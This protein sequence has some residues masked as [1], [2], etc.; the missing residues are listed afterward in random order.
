MNEEIGWQKFCKGNPELLINHDM[1]IHMAF[2]A[3]WLAGKEA[4]K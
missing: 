4:K 2:K 1:I 3:G